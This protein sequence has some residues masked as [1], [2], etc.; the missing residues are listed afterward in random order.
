[1]NQANELFDVTII[2]GGTTGLYTA[3]YSSLREMK[4]KLIEAS[5]FLGGKVSLFFPEKKV[6]DLGAIPGATGEEIV[7]QTIQQATM[8]DP[9]IIQNE[10]VDHIEKQADGTFFLTT[11]NGKTHFSRT[12]IL[13]T[14][15]GMFTIVGPD[16]FDL[17]QD[18]NVRNRLEELE[19]YRGKRVVIFS[20]SR[21]GMEW[22]AALKDIAE[23]VYLFNEKD[24]YVKAKD[25]DFKLIEQQNIKEQ[26]QITLTEVNRKNNNV[27]EVVVSDHTGKQ[28]LLAVDD[29]LVYQGISM[30]QT[31]FEDWGM[32]TEQGR[33]TTN[34]LMATCVDGMFVAGDA[35]I[36]PGKTNLIA[37]GYSEAMTA[38]N[39]AKQYLD[40][41][42]SAQI[43]TTVI[44]RDK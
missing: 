12:V 34:T 17:K 32:Q 18:E 38:V 4:T 36:Y 10:W 43:Y 13:A 31:P 15:N 14:G 21:T 19:Q 26:R 11:A 44:F 3:F 35:A 7:N 29:V 37:S 9:M 23:T 22:A 8:F 6:Y 1:M 41:K 42:A 25:H 39:S 28:E 2:G 5:P 24:N 16:L 40:P 30:K 27:V 33:V 20:N